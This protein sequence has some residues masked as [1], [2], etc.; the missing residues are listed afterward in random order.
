V[1]NMNV[2][3]ELINTG[4]QSIKDALAEYKLGVVDCSEWE[5]FV[6][7]YNSQA[8]AL[9][10]A[11]HMG[12]VLDNDVL[13]GLENSITRP[14]ARVA[15]QN[16]KATSVNSSSKLDAEKQ[17]PAAIRVPEGKRRA[18]LSVNSKKQDPLEHDVGPALEPKPSSEL[19]NDLHESGS[20]SESE[21]ERIITGN[22]TAAEDVVAAS[23]AAWGSNVVMSLQSNM[24]TQLDNPICA[25]VSDNN[26]EDQG[27]S[28]QI[29][30]TNDDKLSPGGRAPAPEEKVD[31]Y[32]AW[33]VDHCDLLQTYF[34]R[35]DLDKSGTL[36]DA[37]ELQY[38]TINVIKAMDI[39]VSLSVV[40]QVLEPALQELGDGQH[41]EYMKFVE[42][43]YTSFI[44][45]DL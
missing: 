27:D 31:P 23:P 34:D 20:E 9:N 37:D 4:E 28:G 25:T 14:E 12:L 6:V 39:K 11:V 24:V 21:S 40:D 43:F 1:L 33:L 41:W 15:L 36:N 44:V 26:R 19:E 13:A 18:R 17:V 5:S 32:E 42:W 38:L 8:D 2:V 16:Y 10:A 22:D 7:K 35:Y 45:T 3:H 29:W 30:G